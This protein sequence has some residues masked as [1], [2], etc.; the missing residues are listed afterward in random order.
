MEFRQSGNGG[1]RRRRVLFEEPLKAT[2]GARDAPAFRVAQ[3]DGSVSFSEAARA[4]CQARITDLLPTRV[5]SLAVVFLVGMT[6]IAA[7]ELLHSLRTSWAWALGTKYF[8]A[9]DLSLPGNLSDWYGAFML[10]CAAIAS[11]LVYTIR[12]HRVDDYRARYRIWLWAGCLLFGASIDAVAGIHRIVQG[13]LIHVTAHELFGDGTIWWMLVIGGI[14]I[15]LVVFLLGD[16]RHSR[17]S[18]SALATSALLYIVSAALQLQL[19]PSL[20]EPLYSMAVTLVTLAGHLMLLM[21][22]LWYARHVFLAAAGVLPVRAVRPK[23][24][25]QPKTAPAASAKPVGAQARSA[26]SQTS[27]KAARRRSDLDTQ[28]ISNA[29]HAAAISGQDDESPDGNSPSRKLSKAE[30][31]RLRKQMRRLKQVG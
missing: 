26:S 5:Y 30:R 7:L 28:K 21:S 2:E 9:L 17:M 22:I 3:P 23:R 12:R 6:V 31:R 11:V 16:I 10:M 14:S 8:T 24:R 18:T 1:G 29:D 15:A 19:L 25:S 13:V 4:D 20:Y 27:N